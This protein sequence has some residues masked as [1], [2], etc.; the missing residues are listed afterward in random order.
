MEA[1]EIQY[2]PMKAGERRRLRVR[3]LVRRFAPVLILIAMLPVLWKCGVMAWR[4]GEMLYW[5]GKAMKYTQPEGRVVLSYWPS[6]G[7]TAAEWERLSRI[8]MPPGRKGASTLFLHERKNGLGESRLVV[9]EN[10]PFL[11]WITVMAPGSVTREPHEVY[12][13]QRVLVDYVAAGGEPGRNF[14]VFA[15]QPDPVDQ[16]HFTIDYQVGGKSFTIDGYLGDDD[17]VDFST[18]E[19]K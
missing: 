8:Y 5:Q 14:T 6:G 15:G 11:A 10:T 18:R 3:R 19:N 4:Q 9:V 2:A 17:R 7:M 16:S 1:A 12:E 13:A